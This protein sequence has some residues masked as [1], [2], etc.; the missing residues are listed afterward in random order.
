VAQLET[1]AEPKELA[2]NTGYQAQKLEKLAG[3]TDSMIDAPIRELVGHINDLP[4]CFTLQCCYG[5]F[6]YDGQRDPYNL[7]ALPRTTRIKSV[8]YR[9]AYVAFCIE[10]SASGRTLLEDLNR[11]TTVD[12]KN[13]QICSAEWFWKKQVNS[14]ALQVEPYRFRHEDKV[15]LDYEEALHIEKVRHEFFVRLEELFQK[16]RITE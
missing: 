8:E 11:I 12:P 1:F 7:E 4:Y 5:H 10:N 6:T 2:K 3:F 15:I 14:Y 16:L 13:V 9:I